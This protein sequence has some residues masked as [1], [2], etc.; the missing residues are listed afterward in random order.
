M[1]S[2]DASVGIATVY[3]VSFGDAHNGNKCKRTQWQPHAFENDSVS[4]GL[5]PYRL[6]ELES[7]RNHDEAYYGT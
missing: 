3:V 6:H 2:D 5:D 4:D 7:D 1:R